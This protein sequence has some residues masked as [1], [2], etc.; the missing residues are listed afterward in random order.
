[1]L[2]NC[3]V[4]HLDAVFEKQPC[5]TVSKYNKNKKL[6]IFVVDRNVLHSVFDSDNGEFYVLVYKVPVSL[7]KN[8]IRKN[9]I[10]MDMLAL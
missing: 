10:P 3:C 8:Y 2:W 6:Y 9:T 4:C 5:N 7:Y 1:M